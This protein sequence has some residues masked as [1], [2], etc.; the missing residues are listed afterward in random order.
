MAQASGW[1]GKTVAPLVWNLYNRTRDVVV[2]CPQPRGTGPCVMSPIRIALLGCGTV[3]RRTHLPAFRRAGRDVVDVTV[4]SSR[5]PVSAEAAATEW[6]GGRVV[7]DWRQALGREDVDAVDICSPNALHLEMAVRAAEAGKHVLVEKPIATSLADADAMIAA[8]HRAGVVLM[9]AHN[10]RFAQG[11]LAARRV[12]SSGGIGEIVGVRTSLGHP[13]PHEWAPE[14]DWF[15]DRNRSGGGALLD[16]GVHLVDLVRAVTGD[17]LDSVTALTRPRRGSHGIDI[18]A[19]VGFRLGRGAIGAFRASWETT[20]AS[21]LELTLV[22]T[23]GT[24]SI[25]RHHPP[26]VQDDKGN[27]S[28]LPLP[29]P[30]NLYGL[31]AGACAAQIPPPVA[32]LDGRAALAGVLAAYEAADAGTMVK[33]RHPQP[34]RA[35]VTAGAPRVEPVP[36]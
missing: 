5:S 13:G 16:L 34:E 31:F 22:G 10:L 4:F 2:S 8:A 32:G 30:V 21:G 3:A 28:D 6:G 33:V 23:T 19:E 25:G 14:A 18:A 7:S 26:F 11:C 15:F 29:A 9:P 35:A 1:G 27:A 17:E 36:L 12:V 20:P 24:L